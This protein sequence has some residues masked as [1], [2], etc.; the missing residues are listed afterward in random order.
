MTLIDRFLRYVKVDTQSNQNSD[1]CPSTKKQFDLANILVKELQ[2]MGA[3]DISLDENCYLMATIPS[4]TTKETP[5]IGFIAHLDTSPDMSG[6]EVNPQIVKNYNGG[7]IVLNKE[8]KVILSPSSFPE[9]ANYV[10]Q[11]LITTDGTTL[12][13][14][15]DKAGVAVIMELAKFLTDNKSFE[16]GEIKIAFTPDEEIGRGADKFDVEKFNAHFAYTVDGGEIGEL[17]YETFN[18]AG[19]KIIISGRNVHPGYAKDKMVNA[20]IIAQE[21]NA[22]LPVNQ[23]PEFT[24]NYDGFFHL[25]SVVSTVEK[26]VVEYIIRDHSTAKFQ[27]KIEVMKLAVEFINNR[28]GKDCAKLEII[29]QYKNMGEIISENMHIVDLAEKAMLK[30]DVKP[31]I[32]PIRGGTDGARL[33]FMGLPTPNIFTGAHNFH[34]RFEFLPIGSIEKSFETVKNIVQLSLTD[35]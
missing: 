35:N 21:L 29:E 24:T 17:E 15:D 4:N 1:S 11:D 33:S 25:I 20:N 31:L 30:A 9:L 13:G 26:A 18:A 7:D 10:G 23:R 32:V 16:H 28:Y 2:E 12:L 14:A 22:L 3:Q 27:N 8:N 5:T 34:G 6:K 19:A